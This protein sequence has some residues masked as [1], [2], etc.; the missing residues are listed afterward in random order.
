[1]QNLPQYMMASMQSELSASHFRNLALIVAAAS[2]MQTLDSAIINT[3]LPAMAKSYGVGTV[4]LSLGVTAYMLASAAV[5]PL[6]AWL[7]S[8]FGAR[9]VFMA[10]MLLFTAA[11]L[12]CGLA[13]SLSLFVVARV[14]QGAG[15][16]LMMP[17]GM[18]VVLRYTPKTRLMHATALTVWPALVAPIVGPILGGFITQNI[19][20]RWNFWLNLPVGLLG[21]LAVRIWVPNE[22]DE[23]RRSLDVPGFALCASALS[24]LIAGFQRSAV[25]GREIWVALL[26]IA[27]GLVCGVAALRHMGKAEH[28]LLDFGPLKHL[29]FNRAALF[30]GFLFR[31][32]FY[33]APFLLPLLFQLGF[34]MSP[35]AA[36]GW[37]F[38]Y[39]CGNLGIKPATTW[40]LKTFGFR[41]VTSIN[42]ALVGLTMIGC[43]FLTQDTPKI[44][45]VLLLAAAGATRS[46]QLTSVMTMV[47]ADVSP[48]QR[49]T[50]STLHSMLIQMASAFGVALGAFLLALFQGLDHA[51]EVRL[52]ELHASFLVVAAFG[53]F[54]AAVY[55]GM[56]PDIGAE[57]SR[58]R[59]YSSG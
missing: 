17:V 43:G 2:F 48:R 29:S 49:N 37:V 7:T 58:H 39:F 1:M 33:T 31:A 28:P 50:A 46:M 9:N 23:A 47:F 8:R 59:K 57:V 42:G 52:H 14:G 21:A 19:D 6:A 34:G 55:W 16:A 12:G 20:W 13:P 51:R 41:N 32:Q 27:V 35:V 38:V 5:S 15:G 45:T 53:L 30:P 56:P 3:S 44:F 18:A 25:G 24:C 26:L 4:D 54:G 10:A 40:I 22:R 36:G 11:S